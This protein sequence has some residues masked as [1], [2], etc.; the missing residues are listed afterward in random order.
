MAM[1]R[2]TIGG[3]GGLDRKMESE[4]SVGSG[5]QGGRVAGGSAVVVEAVVYPPMYQ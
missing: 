5:W 1:R 3:W 4:R 2:R